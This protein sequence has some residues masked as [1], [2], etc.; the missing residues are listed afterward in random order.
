MSNLMKD[1]AFEDTEAVAAVAA[2]FHVERRAHAATINI[3]ANAL[4]QVTLHT[5]IDLSLTELL[6]VLACLSAIGWTGW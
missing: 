3:L 5:E 4:Y 2:K 1:V 6:E